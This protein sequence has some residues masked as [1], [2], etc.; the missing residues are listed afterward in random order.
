[1]KHEDDGN[2][3]CNWRDWN[4]PQIIVKGT[5]TTEI[6]GKIKKTYQISKYSEMYQRSDETCCHSDFIERQTVKFD[7]KNSQRVR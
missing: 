4:G 1:M 3:T 2:T 7:I 6:W 5:G